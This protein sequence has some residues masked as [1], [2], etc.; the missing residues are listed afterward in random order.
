MPPKLSD[1]YGTSAIDGTTSTGSSSAPNSIS[2]PPK[3]PAESRQRHAS[4]S[5]REFME[6]FRTMS[7]YSD[8]YSN[9][10]ATMDRQSAMEL[11]IATK[12][13]CIS[14]LSSTNQTQ[15]DGFEERYRKWNE[16]KMGIELREAGVKAELTATAA[17]E[18]KEMR[19]ELE[20]EKSKVAMQNEK[21]ERASS[22]MEQMKTEYNFC[23]ARLRKWE[24]YTSL[25]KDVDFA[26]FGGKMA[27]LFQR[28]QDVVNRHMLANLSAELF[29]DHAQWNDLLRPLAIPFGVP[30]TNSS[31]AKHVRMAVALHIL[32]TRLCA[33]FFKPCHVPKYLNASQMIEDILAQQSRDDMQKEYIIRALLL[34]MYTPEEVNASMKRTVDA[35]CNE[36]LGLLKHFTSGEEQR[37]R[38][39]LEALLYEAADVWKEAQ[40]SRKMVKAIIVDE[41]EDEHSDS[42]PWFHLEEFGSTAVLTEAQPGSQK[43]EMLN[44]F[45]RVFVPEDNHVVYCGVVLWPDQDIVVSAEQEFKN[46]VRRNKSVRSA[47]GATIGGSV[48]RERRLSIAIDGSDG[49]Q[50]S[51]TSLKAGRKDSFLG[52]P[53]LQTQGS[54]TRN[55]NCGDG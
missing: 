14:C 15:M 22:K 42:C 39:D 18:M 35:T 51:P 17:R 13:A 3:R 40:Y 45:P 5:W 4:R 53:H 30:P 36:V 52:M 32:A 9:I 10:E 55:M 8:E 49:G 47:S 1:S 6:S 46:C 12:D 21:L 24:N 38:M 11:D 20:Y 26:V 50:A 27:Q 54:E 33:N 31:A 44:L 28:C 25:L 19:K 23:N 7:K 34:S 37:F 43:F 41:Q 16:E 29:T 48:R 2:A